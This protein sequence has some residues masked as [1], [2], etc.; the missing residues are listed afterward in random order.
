MPRRARGSIAARERSDARPPSRSRPPS[1]RAERS[2]PALGT[3][4]KASASTYLDAP[5]STSLSAT[6]TQN[7]GTSLK[8]ITLEHRDKKTLEAVTVSITTPS[9]A[10][11]KNKGVQLL[12]GAVP[13]EGQAHEGV[14]G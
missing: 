3:G 4:T 2:D 7:T 9:G 10:T 11:T 14:G 6:I 8:V 12:Q 1:S 13:R 5:T